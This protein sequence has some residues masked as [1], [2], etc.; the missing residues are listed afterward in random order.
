[1][2]TSN[3]L[4]TNA[5]EL[6]SLQR[7]IQALVSLPET[8]APVISCYLQL[9]QGNVKDRDRFDELVRSLGRGVLAENRQDVVDAMPPI[10]AYLQDELSVDTK[11]VAIFSRAGD[12]PFFLAF[13]FHVGVPNWMAADSTPNIYHLVELK[14]TYHRYVVMICSE[15]QAR[16]LEVNLGAVTTQLWAERPELRRRVGREWT[17]EHYQNHRR[18]RSQKFIK[19]KVEVL[20]RLFAAGGHTH[21]ILAGHPAIASR[22]RKELPRHLVE[23]LI[24][25]IPKSAA[26]GDKE[27]V[28]KDVV[29]E[30]IGSFIEAEQEESYEAVEVLV[31]Q[32]RTGGLAVAGTEATFQALCRGHVDVVVIGQH[33][34]PGPG[35][36][37]G[38]CNYADV[39]KS[40]PGACPEC[41]ARVFRDFDIKGAIVRM[42]EQ[43]GCQ[44][45]TVK[46]SDTLAQLG[47]VGC[48]LRYR[49]PED[50]V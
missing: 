46:E 17:K 10:E 29:Q 31:R 36:K 3:T 13:Q 39:T 33:Y 47:H 8:E 2:T 28:D 26:K 30:T 5:M 40:K 48:L 9:N 23:K 25:V 11:G 18:N 49:L 37:C 6:K 22:V 27:K 42:A 1:M 41:C 50:Y 14:D 4:D 19:E 35:W 7:H 32:L 38:E 43:L 34:D 15:E 24:D 12:E 44:V 21:L 16:I 45:E 20:E